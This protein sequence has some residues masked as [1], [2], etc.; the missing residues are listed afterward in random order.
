MLL[1]RDVLRSDPVAL[2]RYQATK[3]DLA[4]RSWTYVQEYADA[5][6]EVVDTILSDAGW[7]G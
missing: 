6:T 4:S 5:K 1:F 3:R 2:D 7:T